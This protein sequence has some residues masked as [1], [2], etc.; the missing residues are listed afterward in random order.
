MTMPTDK[1]KELTAS[2]EYS[3]ILCAKAIK[4]Q[5]IA[6]PEHKQRRPKILEVSINAFST[7]I[8]LGFSL[9]ICMKLE[10]KGGFQATKKQPKYAP[11]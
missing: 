3:L 9:V 11:A 2:L 4:K 7:V 6:V 5:H 8:L 1:C 10:A